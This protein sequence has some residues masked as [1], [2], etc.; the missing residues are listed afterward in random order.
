MRG[1]HHLHGPSLLG[2]GC[3]KGSASVQ[4]GVPVVWT[5]SRFQEESGSL[6]A[7]RR[8]EKQCW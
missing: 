5:E 2:G 1:P 4:V 3:H 7:H 6:L 8:W